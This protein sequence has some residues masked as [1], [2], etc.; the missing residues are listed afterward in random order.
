MD[1]PPA[2]NPVMVE[3]TISSQTVFFLMPI[4]PVKGTAPGE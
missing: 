2:N 1:I 4:F 3:I